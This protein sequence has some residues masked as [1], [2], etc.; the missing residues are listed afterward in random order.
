LCP[1]S[2]LEAAAAN[3]PVEQPTKFNLVINL[4]TAKAKDF[5][6]RTGGVC[7]WHPAEPGCPHSR[8]VLE[9]NR[10]NHGIENSA[11]MTKQG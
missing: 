8:R 2:G 7:F 3:I 11:L 1:I 10:T 6:C 4:T 9:G 5:F